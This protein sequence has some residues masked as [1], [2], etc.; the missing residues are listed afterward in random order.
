MKDTIRIVM[1]SDNNYA[2]LI[3]ALLKSVE[4]NHITGEPLEFYIISDGIRK[5]N[6][7]R[8]S[9]TINPKISRIIWLDKNEIVPPDVQLPLDN[10]GFPLTTYLRVFA[11]SVVPVGTEKLIYLDVDMIVQDDISK[12]W[13]VDIGDC[14]VGAVQDL[15][16]IV[17]SDW[18]GIPNWQALGMKKEA[19]YFNAGLLLINVKKWWEED[20]TTEFIKCME[21][22]RK[23]VNMVDQYGLNVVLHNRWFELDKRWNSFSAAELPDPYLI[24]FLDVKP[25]F[26][27]YRHSDKYK[28]EFYRYLSYTPWKSFK[29]RSGNY[30]LMV[31]ARNK[32]K[33]K[34]SRIFSL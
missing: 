22:N 21:V 33:K 15:A 30:I 24:H 31:K 16:K 3:A 23:H 11:T 5:V 34:L 18:G 4:T 20:V 14:V 8:I 12:L 26:S 17:G 28:Q 25:I 7:R 6:M 19:K 27:T 9:D 13:H 10:S 2:I 32:I 29:P 1:A